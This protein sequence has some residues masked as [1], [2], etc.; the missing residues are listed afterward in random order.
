MRGA[1]EEFS[2]A[3]HLGNG[4]QNKSG[5]PFGKHSHSESWALD[6]RLEGWALDSRLKILAL[7]T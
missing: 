3:T 6:S 4:R 5:P 1:Y 2:Q 7:D